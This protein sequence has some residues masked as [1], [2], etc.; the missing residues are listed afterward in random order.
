MKCFQSTSL[1]SNLASQKVIKIPPKI[2]IV[3]F[4][5]ITE[6]KKEVEAAGL[7]KYQPPKPL[8]IVA[9][10]QVKLVCWM[11]VKGQQKK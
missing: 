5:R 3:D 2:Y 7:Q 11:A 1:I 8:E 6:I 9:E 4:K 10:N